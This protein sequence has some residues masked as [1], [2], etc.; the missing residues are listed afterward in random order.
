[1]MLGDDHHVPATGTYSHIDNGAGIELFRIPLQS[2]G[3][4][5]ALWRTS[6]YAPGIARGRRMTGHPMDEKSQFGIL[7]AGKT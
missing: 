5:N 1:M 2:D 6:A 7:K 3:I 4:G